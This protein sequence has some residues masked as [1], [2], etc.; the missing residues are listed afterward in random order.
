MIKDV[1]TDKNSILD[2]EEFKNL[3]NKI[4]LGEYGFIKRDEKMA[5]SNKQLS[6]STS[7]A[8]IEEEL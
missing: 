5:G 8:P 4:N 1:D 7:L 2:F 6:K 3:V